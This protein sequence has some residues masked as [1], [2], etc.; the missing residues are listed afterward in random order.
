MRGL[1]VFQNPRCGT[2]RTGRPVYGSA[3]ASILALIP[4][5][6]EGPRIGPVVERTQVHL[7]V[8]VVDDG[9]TDDT[10]ERA[11]SAGA[12]VLRQVLN[13]GK[14]AALR[15]GFGHAL[16]HDADAVVTL[17]ADGQHDP[18]EIPRFL[19]AYEDGHPELI[20]GRRNFRT[21]PPLRRL[22]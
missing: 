12:L 20:I 3:V 10:A 1:A 2:P 15:R 14:G 19:T 22:S 4:A 8:V 16:E 17:D 18:A 13:A 5:Y 9:S 6:Q 11:E 21:M 7:R